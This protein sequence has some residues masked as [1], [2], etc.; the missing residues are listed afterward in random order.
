MR[1]L[2]KRSIGSPWGDL[3][4]VPLIFVTPLLVAIT[5]IGAWSLSKALF[6]KE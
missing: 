1:D 5:K 3:Y 4:Y 6:R 2:S